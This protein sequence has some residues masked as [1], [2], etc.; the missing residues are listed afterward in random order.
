MEFFTGSGGLIEHLVRWVHFFAG[1]AWIGLL[2]Y[3][4]LV[5]TEYFKEAGDAKANAIDKLVPRALWWFRWGA[6]F[7]FLSGLGL[8]YFI[9]INTGRVLNFYIL[10]GMALGILMFL[11]VWLVIWPNQKIVIASNRQV[12]E[13][14]E[15]LTEAAAAQGKAGLASRT[16]TLFSLPMLFFMGAS[17]HLSG[18][19]GTPI[20]GG[21]TSLL[22]YILTFAIIALLEFNAIKG[23]T[24]PITSVSGVIHSS[25]WLTAVLVLII[26]FL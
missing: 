9:E 1:V 3:F 5:Q 21:N 26:E 23:K 20:A 2:Y 8:A 4:N 10:I 17:A 13:G 11:N 7:T 18:A 24:G 16:N 6:M 15:P 19:G 12:L 25:V 14:G 22:V